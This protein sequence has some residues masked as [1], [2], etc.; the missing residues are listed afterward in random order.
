MKQ[1]TLR[2]PS[3]GGATDQ[4]EAQVHRHDFL[5]RPLAIGY[6]SPEVPLHW[7]P[8]RIVGHWKRAL[9][10][11]PLCPWEQRSGRGIGRSERR[12]VWGGRCAP[13]WAGCIRACCVRGVVHAP[14]VQDALRSQRQR[15]VS[16][17]EGHQD[18]LLQLHPTGTLHDVLDRLLSTSVG[19]LPKP[20]PSERHPQL[21]SSPWSSQQREWW[22]PTETPRTGLMVR[23]VVRV[24][25]A[26]IWL[27]W[28]SIS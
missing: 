21:K 6:P 26:M 28:G 23:M 27:C 3:P 2:S 25:C 18:V 9:Q 19:K 17:C 15:V 12:G 11:Y 20:R 13:R 16:G 4:S 14:L 5:A 24:G 8:K 10:N 22:R 1:P 7:V